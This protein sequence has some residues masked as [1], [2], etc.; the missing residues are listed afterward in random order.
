[1]R[2]HGAARFLAQCAAF[3]YMAEENASADFTDYAEK[4]KRHAPTTIRLAQIRLKLRN[5]RMNSVVKKAPPP[6]VAAACASLGRDG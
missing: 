5:P 4:S 1:M 2:D 3:Q 6:V